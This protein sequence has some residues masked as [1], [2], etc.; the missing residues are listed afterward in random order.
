MLISRNSSKLAARRIKNE[1]R[2]F[3]L[4]FPPS[5]TD[6]QF[7]FMLSGIVGLVCNTCKECVSICCIRLHWNK[8]DTCEILWLKACSSMGCKHSHYAEPKAAEAHQIVEESSLRSTSDVPVNAQEDAVITLFKTCFHDGPEASVCIERLVQ[9]RQQMLEH[10]FSDDP[11]TSKRGLAYFQRL[12]EVTP[13]G[14][15]IAACGLA[16]LMRSFLENFAIDR[17]GDVSLDISTQIIHCLCLITE[18]FNAEH[19]IGNLPALGK[20]DKEALW[21]YADNCEAQNVRKSETASGMIDESADVLQTLWI[22]TF[23]ESVKRIKTSESNASNVIE[24]VAGTAGAAI[25]LYKGDIMAGLSEL[26]DTFRHNSSVGRSWYDDLVV[27]RKLCKDAMQDEIVF[28]Q[29]RWILA[30][31]SLLREAE[32]SLEPPRFLMHVVLCMEHLIAGGG[33]PY[34][35]EEAFQLLMQYVCI[36]SSYLQYT[37]VKVLETLAESESPAQITS[38]AKV[39]LQLIQ[40]T[41][42]DQS[43]DPV[44]R[45]LAGHLARKFKKEAAQRLRQANSGW[46][47]GGKAS[48]LEGKDYFQ[49]YSSVIAHLMSGLSEGQSDFKADDTL[50]HMASKIRSRHAERVVDALKDIYFGEATAQYFTKRSAETGLTPVHQAAISGVSQTLRW[51]LSAKTDQGEGS[52]MWKIVTDAGIQP[53]HVAGSVQV[54]DLLLEKRARLDAKDNDGNTVLH[55]LTS[56]SV[57][58]HVLREIENSPSL[59]DITVNTVNQAGQ[60][61]LFTQ[62]VIAK[63]LERPGTIIQLLLKFRADLHTVAGWTA[64]NALHHAAQCDNA[65]C[66]RALMSSNIDV[67]QQDSGGHL[68]LHLAGPK[69][70]HCLLQEPLLREAVNAKTKNGLTPLHCASSVVVMQELC[71]ARADV[72]VE[73]QSGTT[74][75]G[76]VGSEDPSMLSFLLGA[77]ADPSVKSEWGD[78]CFVDAAFR[79]NLSTLLMFLEEQSE[80][81]ALFALRGEDGLN[82]MLWACMKSSTEFVYTL[83]SYMADLESVMG[84]ASSDPG[85]T[86]MYVASMPVRRFL[87]NWGVDINICNQRDGATCLHGGYRSRSDLQELL[88][89]RADPC[90]LTKHGRSTLD[91]LLQSYMRDQDKTCCFQLLLDARAQIHGRHSLVQSWASIAGMKRT[92]NESRQ[93]TQL[94]T[95]LLN[96]KCSVNAACPATGSTALAEAVGGNKPTAWD[97]LLESK[98]DPYRPDFCGR[99]PLHYAVATKNVEWVE[100]VLSVSKDMASVADMSGETPA[101]LASRLDLLRLCPALER[102]VGRNT[103][104]RSRASNPRSGQSMLAQ[105][106]QTEN[107]SAF[108]DPWLCARLGL[109]EECVQAL[110]TADLASMTCPVSGHT[111]LH[112]AVQGGSL[113]IVKRILARAPQLSTSKG[114]LFCGGE[115]RPKTPLCMLAGLVPA[116]SQAEEIAR[117]LV[118]AAADPF[119]QVPMGISKASL[120]L[121]ATRSRGTLKVLLESKVEV[122]GDKAFC[123]QRKN[124]I[125]FGVDDG[126]VA[127]LLLGA[128]ATMGPAIHGRTALHVVESH[129]A[130]EAILEKDSRHEFIN[131]RGNMGETALYSHIFRGASP[132][133]VQTL[134]SATAD[135]HLISSAGHSLLHVVQGNHVVDTIKMLLEA[136]L[137][138]NC[139]DS[140]GQSTLAFINVFW[141]QAHV[142]R[143]LDLLVSARADLHHKNAAGT[144]LLF[145]AAERRKALEYF[146]DHGV[147]ASLVDPATEKDLVLHVASSPSDEAV[148]RLKLLEARGLDILKSR[149]PNGSTVLH[150][151]ATGTFEAF[152]YILRKICLKPDMFLDLAFAQEKVTQKTVVHLLV[153]GYQKTAQLRLF[154][155]EA[156]T[157]K[158][159]SIDLV[160]GWDT[161]SR[162]LGVPAYQA[163]SVTGRAQLDGIVP[164]HQNGIN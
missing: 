6:E 100:R 148:V 64:K 149:T 118:Q 146:L 16:T 72:N 38:T 136:R 130:V 155:N 125:W 90:A 95:C 138:P 8:P 161:A 144:P 27:M 76:M 57:L 51:M 162:L 158:G 62:A 97:A 87:N 13:V 94:L 142:A 15:P 17:W 150:Q 121:Q 127:R 99:V 135:P 31:G 1:L 147:A 126:E 60:P 134:L 93:Y 4:L 143:G 53:I 9:V 34:I 157:I 119:E 68:A 48:E 110:G 45:N 113:N 89:M 85:Q 137:D 18:S 96:L 123:S 153:Q 52:E 11:T 25:K 24:T 75:L 56:V 66:C 40:R 78:P 141:E 88:D 140:L 65:A 2:S 20:Q 107:P 92:E 5:T 29:L 156:R 151:A 67:L 91:F 104:R 139:A 133:L 159:F 36:P 61:P 114:A 21:T 14:D 19:L 112:A 111:I 7:Q 120:A 160:M 128:G 132:E 43:D 98:G 50:V 55:T 44:I 102:P 108:S 28:R 101:D 145:E 33:S 106:V 116:P 82:A 26:K 49:G 73:S 70:I 23:L 152:E 86:T 54:M 81:S 131:H 41:L 37:A 117:C 154:L 3:P 77:K 164:W 59:V 129:A 74:P 47:E 105:Q 69:S 79:G 22:S 63:G 83:H 163:Q 115:T 12:L 58:H 10:C 84:D 30:S 32:T 35:Q 103:L 71:A 109:E 122:T 42:L 39:T 46:Y 124:W 80:H